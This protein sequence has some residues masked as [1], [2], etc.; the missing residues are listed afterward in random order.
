[1]IHEKSKKEN[2][3]KDVNDLCMAE[4][5]YNKGTVT[6]YLHNPKYGK[7]ELDFEGSRYCLRHY[8]SL[9]YGN[10]VELK[11]ITNNLF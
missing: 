3:E 7:H 6:P 11:E 9:V 8:Y 5:C 2:S 10:N 4:D 1:M